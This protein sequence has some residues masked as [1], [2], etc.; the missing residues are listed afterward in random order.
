[1]QHSV[2]VL[3]PKG[4][5]DTD[6]GRLAPVIQIVGS[7][8]RT[9]QARVCEKGLSKASVSCITWP[10]FKLQNCKPNFGILQVGGT[11]V[12]Q[13]LGRTIVQ[14]HIYHNTDC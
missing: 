12:A 10:I 11:Q 3:S 14:F 4:Q 6:V 8:F 1:M 5:Q 13:M 7:L 9:P 2:R